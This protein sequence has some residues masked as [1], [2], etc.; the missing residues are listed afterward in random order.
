MNHSSSIIA[1]TFPSTFC[2]VDTETTGMRPPYS[3]VMDIGIIRIENGVE[4]ERFSTLLNAGTTV[5]ARI[6]RFTG[7]ATED[8]ATAPAFEDVALQIQEI[9]A[10]AVFVAHNVPF[11][12]SFIRSEF[13]R[14][15]MTFSPQTLCSVKLSRAL[16]PRARSHSLDAV[17][18]RYALPIRERH[19]ALPDAEA[20]WD[21][22]QVLPEAHAKESI[23]RA[24]A[25]AMGDVRGG[26]HGG[27]SS[28]KASRDVFTEL[29]S[30]SGVYFFYGK[31]QELLYIGKSKH[32]RTR[33]RSHFHA[34]QDRKELRLQEE[35]ATVSAI[36][37][38][39]ELSA[40][41]LEAALIKQQNPMYNRALR[42]RKTLVIAEAT[43]HP[44]G[45]PTLSLTRTADLTARDSIL[46][47]F[48]TLTQG[49]V[50][51]RTLAKEY[52]LCPK[53]LGIE[54]GAGNGACFA[55]QLG[56][57]RGACVG[58]DD[59]AAYR[60]RFEE[61]F[62]KRRMRAWPYKG[63]VRIDERH[64]EDAGTV[65]F[66]EDWILKGAY[67]YDTDTFEPLIENEMGTD[68]DYD[69]YKILVRYLLNPK[70]RRSVSVIQRREYESWI[71][72]TTGSEDPVE[73][74]IF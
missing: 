23:A 15:G 27:V 2:I 36:P 56:A 17:I 13:A 24:A 54:S 57:C 6:E 21:F 4:V 16:T 65:F 59:P 9:L 41:I 14:L 67:R 55:H 29:P 50:A 42:K 7:I 26:T 62:K 31:D 20:V 69:T 73:T 66:I 19:R 5:P 1:N 18:D 30:E 53:L 47:V 40:L 49:K 28:I 61:A 52:S 45:Y 44:L 3:R 60:E 33:A 63:I 38:S 25:Y 35:T 74:T 11:D 8:L 51:L 64:A 43:E 39:G 12:F 32:V 22:I 68:F 70:N 10:N 37:T 58:K 72:R 34:S 48:R 71:S 46:G